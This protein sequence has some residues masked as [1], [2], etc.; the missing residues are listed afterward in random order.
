MTA[1]PRRA[2]ARPGRAAKPSFRDLVRA[3]A[4]WSHPWRMGRFY[5]L[6]EYHGNL[7]TCVFAEKHG[8]IANPL[9]AVDRLSTAVTTT[10]RR[11]QLVLKALLESDC[12]RWLTLRCPSTPPCGVGP[13]STMR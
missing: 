7:L 5:S 1:P 6:N 3:A 10:A 12:S 2:L 8:K 9:V 11:P 13:P 4:F